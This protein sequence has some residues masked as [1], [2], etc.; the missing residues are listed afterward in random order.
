MRKKAPGRGGRLD[1]CQGGPGVD[2]G[3]RGG[4]GHPPGE[5]NTGITYLSRHT[6]D[7][8]LDGTKG[9]GALGGEAPLHASRGARGSV[10][11][12][13]L[14]VIGRWRSLGFVVYIQQQISSFC[15]GVSVKMST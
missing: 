8:E 14:M 15:A 11:Y 1:L 10:P 7:L 9:S 12:Q 6:G 13:T 3:H 2:P 4:H 5:K